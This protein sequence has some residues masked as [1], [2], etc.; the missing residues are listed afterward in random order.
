[1][2][3]QQALCMLF[4]GGERPRGLAQ[5]VLLQGLQREHV[6]FAADSGA[7][8]LLARGLTP[9]VLVGDGDSLSPAALQQCHN[10]G[11]EIYQLPRE[12]DMTDGEA[13][14][15]LALRKGYREL[16]LFGAFGG[17]PDH[18]LGN[19]LMPL[20]YRAQWQSLTFYSQDSYAYYC[21]G[22][23]EIEGRIGDTVSLVPLSET[24][25]D[26]HLLGFRYPLQGVDTQLGSSL[27][28]RNELAMERALIRFRS[29]IM[30][31]VH[32]PK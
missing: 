32:T 6:M 21:F 4:L 28:L 15:Q 13:A 3:D 19:L 16:A 8:H 27:C 2:A 24:V 9:H 1:M 12:K 10:A 22:D 14:L 30:L 29:G 26:I 7:M 20:P 23:S 31:V 5:R 18:L 11:C 17:K 25:Q